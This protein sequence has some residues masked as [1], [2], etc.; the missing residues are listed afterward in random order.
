MVECPGHFGHLELAKPVFHI[1]FLNKTIKIL[2]CVCYYCS[3]MLISPNNPKIKEILAE[4]KNNPRKRLSH[5]YDLCKGK[6]ICEDSGDSDLNKEGNEFDQELSLKK[7][8]NMHGGCGRFQPQVRREGLDLTAEWKHLNE[9][10]QEKKIVLTAE[11]IHQI[12]KAISDEEVL[13]LGMD[14]KYSRPDW[15]MVT[16]LPVP[17]LC[18]RP[19]VVMFGS[20]RNQDD[21]THKLADIVKINNELMKNEQNG[22]ATHIIAE[23]V[24]MLQFHVATFVD[25]EIPGIPRAQQKSGRPLKSIKQRL[26]AK[27]G[28]IRGNLMGKR[29]DFSARTVITP[30]PNLRID[31]VG[32]P[33][34]IAQNLTFPEIVTPFNIGMLCLLL[35][36]ANFLT[37][38]CYLNF[39]STERVGSQRTR[40]IS[41]RQVHHP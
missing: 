38:D 22:A 10:S 20:A 24:K 16:V 25:N 3:K 31:E 17:P 19:A 11:R 2:R 5:V 33:R 13:C 32:V 37:C 14:P 9:D 8:I 1:G 15:M 26:K 4:T 40:S 12:F 6:N 27:E 30:D 41:W 28:R 7:K 29:V 39:R 18:V 21:L 34:S 36:L 35:R 23:N